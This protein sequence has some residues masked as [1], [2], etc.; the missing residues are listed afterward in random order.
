MNTVREKE[1]ELN[2]RNE[3]FCSPFL[4]PPNFLENKLL[5]APDNKHTNLQQ[6]GWTGASEF[7]PVQQDSGSIA[8]EQTRD[9]NS[10]TT[11]LTL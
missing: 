9:A 3:F 6:A 10:C 8:R 5:S 4:E 11:E 2:M 7:Y 1:K